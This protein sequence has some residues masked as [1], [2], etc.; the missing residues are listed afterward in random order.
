MSNEI[1]A[2]DRVKA[3]KSTP[4]MYLI[5]RG[6]DITKESRSVICVDDGNA[7]LD[8]GFGF[9]TIPCK[10]L[11]KAN[12]EE[13]NAKNEWGPYA[14]DWDGFE[15]QHIYTPKVMANIGENNDDRGAEHT[16]S[17]WLAYTADLAK[18]IAL[19]VT[20]R[21]NTAHEA[22]EYAVSLAKAVVKE[23]KKK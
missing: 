17:S 23:L 15:L 18:E 16:E 2:G 22:A 4:K 3:S 13:D 8:D 19:K 5:N 7:T 14:F 10:Y 9:F 11:I 12:A 20:N 21:Y 1:K 6:C